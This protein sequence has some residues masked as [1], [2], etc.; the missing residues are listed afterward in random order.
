M[1]K[2]M[3]KIAAITMLLSVMG[4]STAFAAETTT[5]VTGTTN[6]TITGF[7][8]GNFD[9]VT[10]NGTTKTTT[11]AVSP[12][13]LT[14]AR[15]TGGGW[16][17][18]LKATTFTNAEAAHSALK[19]LPPNS[20]ALGVVS[21]EAGTDSTPVTNIVIGSGAI[22]NPSGV[23]ILDAGINE[24]MGIYTVNIAPM[25]LTLLPKDAKAG[26]YTSTITMTF[27]EG[28]SI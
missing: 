8:A 26:T 1:L 24:G 21:I 14:D 28:P 3:N 2:K 11:S 6:A 9:A 16:D 10:L 18:T 20:L 27:A 22:D 25:T 17:V 15:G 7:T 5:G 19:T 4:T 13:T 12:I 23:T